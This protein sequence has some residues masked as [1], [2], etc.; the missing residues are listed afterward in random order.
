MIVNTAGFREIGPE[1]IALEEQLLAISKETG[2]RIF[3]PNCQ[4]IINTDPAV[5]AYCNFTFTRPSPGHISIV[6]Q[7]GG[8]GEVIH[9]RIAELGVGVREYASNGNACDISIPS[10]GVIDE[11]DRALFLDHYVNRD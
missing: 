1:G 3:G 10:D 4:G 5:R 9:Q 6:A 7:S 8:V 11:I 2:I